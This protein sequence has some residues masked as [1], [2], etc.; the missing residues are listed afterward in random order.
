MKTTLLTL[1]AFAITLTS[2]GQA[3]EAFK[4]QAVV[5]DAGGII[6]NNQAVG[7]QLTILQGSALGTAVYTE[8]FNPTTN[9]YGLV[10][11][12]IGTGTT[13]DDFTIIDWGNGPYFMETSVDITGGTSYV[14]MGTSQLVSV[15]YALYAKTSGNG[16][17]PVGPQ[18]PAGVDGIDGQDGAVGATGPQGPI[19]L[20]GAPG[21]D[22]IDGAV[23]P[24]GPIGLTSSKGPIGPQGPK[25]PTGL[26]GLKG[27]IGIK[28]VKGVKGVKG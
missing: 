1:I 19:G 28:G 20:T 24:Q 2:F 7:Y 18:G 9:G 22:G 4:Y 15:P 11:L 5:R 23:G 6:L 26:K 25:G 14:V 17:G 3:P 21:I 8:T 13:T 10:N 16:A 27:I 12:E